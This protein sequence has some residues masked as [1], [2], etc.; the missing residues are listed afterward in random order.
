MLSKL[1]SVDV[2][3]LI[4]IFAARVFAA[5]HGA[6]RIRSQTV[7]LCGAT[8]LKMRRWYAPSKVAW[9]ICDR[10]GPTQDRNESLI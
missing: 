6:T 2:N 5:K 7:P 1:V 10:S 9:F 8:C 4:S 3:R